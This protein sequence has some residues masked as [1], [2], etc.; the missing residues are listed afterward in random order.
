MAI[1]RGI[2]LDQ[3]DADR[4]ESPGSGSDMSVTPPTRRSGK[5]KTGERS[6][7]KSQDSGDRDTIV[8]S[9]CPVPT[10]HNDNAQRSHTKRR[11]GA[12]RRLGVTLPQIQRVPKISHLLSQ[13][14][15]GISTVIAALRLCD[16]PGAGEFL[17]RYDSLSD[18]DLAFVTVEDICVA[19]NVPVKRLLELAVSSLV[20]DS[21]SAGAIVAATYHPRVIRAT[22]EAAMDHQYGHA[23][24]RL[25]LQGTG[26]LPQPSNRA[27]GGVFSPTINLNMGVPA[28]GAGDGD[29]DSDQGPVFNAAEDDL[30]RLHSELDGAKLLE[31]PKVIENAASIQIGHTYRDQDAG[32]ECVPVPAAVKR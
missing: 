13:A 5:R 32:L 12:L 3:F 23:D 26:Y 31:A 16:D 29:S 19:A 22:A 18:T 21:K 27:A 1:S 30:Q 20:E 11:A 17:D 8:A 15:G 7:S 24:R 10:Q 4:V 9:Q 25:F 28:V 2:R 14:E 6:R